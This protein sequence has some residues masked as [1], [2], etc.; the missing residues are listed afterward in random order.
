MRRPVNILFAL[1]VVVM[2]CSHSGKNDTELVSEWPY[3]LF[4]GDYPDPSILV[5]GDDYYFTCNTSYW[6][7]ALPVWHSKDLVNWDFVCYALDKYVGTVWAPEIQKIDGRYVIYF[8]ADR[9]IY[10]VYADD[11]GGP[12]SD[13]VDLGVVAIDPGFVEDGTGHRCL[14]FHAGQMADLAPDGL[15]LVSP[16][17]HA[18]DPWP[19]PDDWET[20]G[21]QLESPKFVER[22]GW[23]YLTSAEGGTYGPATGHMAVVHRSRGIEGPWEPS[24]YNPVIHT[25]SADEEWWSKGHGTLFADVKGQW[26]MI[27]HAYRKGFLTLGRQTLIEP[28]TWTSDGWPVVDSTAVRRMPV[29]SREPQERQW[30]G[31]KG[32]KTLQSSV[33]GDT[34]YM[35]SAHVDIA[36]M[37]QG[38][39]GLLLSYSD[40]Y[41]TGVTV[42]GDSLKVWYVGRPVLAEANNYGDSLIMKII[43]DCHQVR[44]FAGKDEASL[45]Q[46]GDVLDVSGMETNNLRPCSALRPAFQQPQGAIVDNVSYKPL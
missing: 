27:Y 40:R 46:I 26:W 14:Y 10:A 1:L 45:S 38:E 28:I 31:W 25:W 21:V 39:A 11:M 30:F 35:L 18:Y 36:R 8:P 41:F 12:W 44:L 16:L 37:T 3:L 29:R 19:I 6:Y 13:P 2:S 22:D 23:Y 20:Q 32:S 33:T 4:A 43:N 9:N 15:S 5:D 42:S 24:P 17:R 34:S 7:P